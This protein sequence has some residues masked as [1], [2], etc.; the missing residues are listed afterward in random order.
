MLVQTNS[1]FAGK[2]KMLT[3][4]SRRFFS[5]SE[6]VSAGASFGAIVAP[7]LVLAG[8]FYAVDGKIEQK[9]NHLESKIDSLT[10]VV[11]TLAVS[12]ARIEER[13]T[14]LR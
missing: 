9:T 11:N 3:R 4:A 8:A 2:S 7:T 1:F 14:P 10:T 12:V 5:G 6:V 13:I